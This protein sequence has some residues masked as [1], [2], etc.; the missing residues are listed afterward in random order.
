MGMRADAHTGPLNCLGMGGTWVLMGNAHGKANWTANVQAGMCARV[1]H[2]VSATLFLPNCAIRQA[3][4]GRVHGACL[5]VRPCVRLRGHGKLVGRH[6]QWSRARGTVD[7]SSV[8]CARSTACR[9]GTRGTGERSSVCLRALWD[10]RLSVVR[11]RST[12]CQSG[13]HETVDC[14]SVRLRACDR[15]CASRGHG[16]HGH[17]KGVCARPTACRSGPPGKT[18]PCRLCVSDCDC[19]TR[20]HG[21]HGHGKGTAPQMG[22][23]RVLGTTWTLSALP[24]WCESSLLTSNQAVQVVGGH[25]A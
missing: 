10:G 5:S 2:G 12:A 20:G 24:D 23:S 15:D 7:C 8:V 3:G 25:C 18:R 13:A 9:S 6:G 14:L 11:A 21:K 17:E 19:T 1:A 4:Q 22:R 16:K